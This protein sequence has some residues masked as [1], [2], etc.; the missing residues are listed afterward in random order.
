MATAEHRA[1]YRRLMALVFLFII[2]LT[3]VLLVRR[4]RRRSRAIQSQVDGQ[5]RPPGTSGS[6][7]Q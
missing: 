7:P 5:W 2:L 1:A 6:H 3:A 4:R